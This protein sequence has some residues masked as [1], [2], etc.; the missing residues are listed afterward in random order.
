MSYQPSAPLF[1]VFSSEFHSNQN[2]S[3]T[4]NPPKLHIQTNH[5]T[6]L[7]HS[8]NLRKYYPVSSTNSA[9]LRFQRAIYGNGKGGI[10]L[11]KHSGRIM[12]LTLLTRILAEWKFKEILYDYD[13][14]YVNQ[15]NT[16]ENQT[17]NLIL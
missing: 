6:R 8:P 16:A 4:K 1:C 11:Q 17:F 3:L 10:Y 5:L 12:T 9:V 15:T 7:D 14:E 13:H 2:Q